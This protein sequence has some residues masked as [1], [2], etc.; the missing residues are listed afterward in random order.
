M[1]VDNLD[2]IKKKDFFA[3]IIGSGPAGITTALEL[4]RKK[5]KTL[6]IE[7]GEIEPNTNIQKFLQGKV[8]G[9]EYADISV[10][11]LRQFGGASGH[12]GGNCN[13]MNEADLNDWPIKKSDLEQYEN[14]AK[15][16]LNLHY[17]KNF[18][19][20][21]FSE[22][23]NIYNLVWSNVRFAEKYFD[24]IK[25]SKYIHLSLNTNFL[26]FNGNKKTINSIN[27]IKN[28]NKIILKSKYFILSCGGIENSR[29]LLW[30]KEINKDMFNDKLP[31]GK[32]YMDHPYHSIGDGLILYDK[33]I[34]YF[35]K[36]NLNNRPILTC[37]SE[38]YMSAKDTFIKNKGILN[39][40]L[41]FYF[42]GI[43][44]D[45][46]IFKQVR[47]VA[48]NFIKEVYEKLRVK[49]KYKVSIA[50]QQGQKADINNRIILDEKKDPL[51]IPY[52]IIYWKKSKIEKKSAKLI[53]EDLSKLFIDN[54][55]GRISLDEHL[56]NNDDYDV[57][58]GNHQ[59]GGTRI[60]TDINDSVVD[61]NLKLHDK[62]NL[63]INGSSIFRTSGHSHP[64]F[65]IVKFA[66]RLADHLSKIKI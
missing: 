3:I 55:I 7:A 66:A 16:I 62:N 53:A 61:I 45:N 64:T 20:E 50:I 31:I 24:H 54:D 25:K 39:A 37:K 22:N 15:K 42:E 18:F 32:Y 21:N 38:M 51:N 23:L 48:P 27:C 58:A 19:L 57:L 4:E 44:E 1:I 5:I 6:I 11:R 26:N 33:L 59:L 56:Y 28:K 17:K 65:T 12:W 63:F 60:G 10:S 29:M 2:N 46:N 9:D 52:P 34:S 40:G 49:E 13:P 43:N 36:N 47:C 30:S 35:K 8:I 14:I 41:Y